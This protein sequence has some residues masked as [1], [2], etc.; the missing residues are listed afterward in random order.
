VHELVAGVDEDLAV[1]LPL[2]LRDLADHVAPD[3][4]RVGPFRILQGGGHDELG[5]AVQLVCPLAASGKPTRGEPLVAA[6]PEQQG[7][8]P[9]RLFG[10]DLGPAFEILSAELA[11]P[12]PERESLLAIWVLDHPVERDVGGDD[13]LSH[14]GSPPLSVLSPS[15]IETPQH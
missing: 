2:Q 11:E 5:H 3:D 9:Q 4:G 8:G 13:N 14:F 6:P 10:L 7:L 1:D 15:G 12:A